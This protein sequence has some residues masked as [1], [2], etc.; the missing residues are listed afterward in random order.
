MRFKVGKQ[1]RKWKF[2][3]Q[4][5]IVFQNCVY[6]PLQKR[7]LRAA[8]KHWKE[9]WETG[10]FRREG[11][12]ISENIIDKGRHGMLDL[13]NLLIHELFTNRFFLMQD[14][15][16]AKNHAGEETHG[17]TKLIILPLECFKQ[18]QI[19]DVENLVNSDAELDTTKISQQKTLGG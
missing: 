3:S 18:V 11:V 2:N 5:V 19:K 14:M 10:Q 17:G 8:D 9:L 6:F 4:E 7:Y 12:G 1:L 16:K 15:E 13:H